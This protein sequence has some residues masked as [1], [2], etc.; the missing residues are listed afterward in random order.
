MSFEVSA[1]VWGCNEIRT[2]YQESVA[3]CETI[4]CCGEMLNSVLLRA[5]NSSCQVLRQMW[6]NTVS[7]GKWFTPFRGGDLPSSFSLRRM[8]FF[9][10]PIHMKAHYHS[11]HLK[12]EAT[13]SFETSSAYLSHTPWVNPRNQEVSLVPKR[14]F[15]TILRLVI[16]QKTDEFSSAA[17]VS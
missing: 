4:C 7:L 5:P 9:F 6:H 17:A 1:S 14:R 12:S 3:Y 2:D 10:W 11:L 8:S 15:Q 16:S 13:K